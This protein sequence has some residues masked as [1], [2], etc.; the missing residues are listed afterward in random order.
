MIGAMSRFG[1]TLLEVL[2]TIAILS[3]LTGM[4]TPLYRQYLFRSDLNNAGQQTI[5]TLRRAQL[6]SRAGQENSGWGVCMPSTVLYKGATYIQRN[7][8]FDET[9]PVAPTI[10]FYG[11]AEVSFSQVEGQ[12]SRTG[13]IILQARNGDRQVITVDANGVLSLRAGVPGSGGTVVTECD[14]TSGGSGSS[15]SV[16]SATGSVVTNG[17]IDVSEVKINGASTTS[18][19]GTGT[20]STVEFTVIAQ[21]GHRD[22][23]FNG[24]S[25]GLNTD[26]VVILYGFTGT[27]DVDVNNPGVHGHVELTGVSGMAVNGVCR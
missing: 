22:M 2:L 25:A 11:L 4:G 3:V 7:I 13:S 9:Y 24:V 1:F 8:G 10:T 18:A 19:Q 17:H 21:H 26:D 27:Y 14:A 6:L 15:S 12:P 20:F 23:T 5:Q 16:C